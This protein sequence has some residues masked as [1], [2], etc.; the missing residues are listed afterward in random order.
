MARAA[1][2]KN[3]TAEKKTAAE[4]KP[5]ATRQ[6][7]VEPEAGTTATRRRRE[8]RERDPNK[9][10]QPL[11]T[12]MMFQADW[13]KA[14]PKEWQKLK[15]STKDVRD[16]ANHFKTLYNNLSDAEMKR[17]RSRYDADHKK[18]KAAMEKYNASK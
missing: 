9:P 7:K 8:K 17:L 6:R 15:D 1:T 5:K 10:K 13:K 4:A 2:A 16:Y 11:N 14:N 18:Y 12:Y 3:A